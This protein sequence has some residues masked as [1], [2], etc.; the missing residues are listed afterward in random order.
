ML[1]RQFWCVILPH[2]A[3]CPRYPALLILL[4]NCFYPA[5]DN[6]GAGCGDD[7]I[8]FMTGTAPALFEAAVTRACIRVNAIRPSHA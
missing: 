8:G 5:D 1:L 3:S 4:F 2:G 6:Q 7:P